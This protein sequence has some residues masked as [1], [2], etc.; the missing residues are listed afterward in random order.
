MELIM[1]EG[2][3]EFQTFAITWQDWIVHL[4]NVYNMC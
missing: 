1:K 2:G 3:Q 4:K